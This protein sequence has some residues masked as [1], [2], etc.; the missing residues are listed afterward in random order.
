MYQSGLNEIAWRLYPT[1]KG[2]CRLTAEKKMWVREQMVQRV[3]DSWREDLTVNEIEK[4]M[5]KI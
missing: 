1:L 3:L 5:K 2:D 4:I